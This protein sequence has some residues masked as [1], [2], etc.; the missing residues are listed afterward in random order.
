MALVLDL[1]LGERRA[2][3][4]GSVRECHLKLSTD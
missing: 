4:W 1:K 2:L 3:P